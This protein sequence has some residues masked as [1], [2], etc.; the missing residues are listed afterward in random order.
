MLVEQKEPKQERRYI[1]QSV[2]PATTYKSGNQQLYSRKQDTN[3]YSSHPG[4]KEELCTEA[5]QQVGYAAWLLDD[6]P[7]IIA[8]KQKQLKLL[9]IMQVMRVG[10]PEKKD[11]RHTEKTTYQIPY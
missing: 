6:I 2:K 10:H 11:D 5:P 4:I 1:A 8:I 7:H 3:N 9:L